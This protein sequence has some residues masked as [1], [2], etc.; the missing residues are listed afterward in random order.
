[1]IKIKN[2]VYIKGA[3]DKKSFLTDA[4]RP[5]IA[6]SGRS[7]VGKSSLIN[8]LANQGKLARVS[9]EPGRTRLVNYFDFGPFILADLPGYGFA[10]VS[11][12]EKAR[13]GKIMDD[14]FSEERF[15]DFVFAL[16]DIR[17]EPTEDDRDMVGFLYETGIPFSIIATKADKLS[18]SQIGTRR[19]DIANFFGCGR[20]DVVVTSSVTGAGIGDVLEIIETAVSV[21]AGGEGDLDE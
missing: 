16:C 7:N 18:R 14:F 6:V 8:K 20:D 10:K 15:C 4:E 12:E 1:M 21:K 2:A 9:K 19:H 17:H 3:A 13:W 11:K 5:I